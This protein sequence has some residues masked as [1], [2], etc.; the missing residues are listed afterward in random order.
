MQTYK[1]RVLKFLHKIECSILKRNRG[2]DLPGGDL[3]KSSPGPEKMDAKNSRHFLRFST[4]DL[5]YLFLKA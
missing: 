2:F 1:A 3:P 5:E 4:F